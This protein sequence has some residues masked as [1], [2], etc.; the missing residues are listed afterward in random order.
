MKYTVIKP[1]VPSTE[2]HFIPWCNTK[3]MK[4]N[5]L[6]PHKMYDFYAKDIDVTS[7]LDSRARHVM[8]NESLLS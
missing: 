6:V 2:L 7:F 4:G 1:A 3:D 8:D 5:G